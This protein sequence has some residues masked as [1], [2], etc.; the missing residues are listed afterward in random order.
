M[1]NLAVYQRV[2]HRQDHQHKTGED[3]DGDL[4][5]NFQVFHAIGPAGRNGPDG[6]GDA[7]VDEGAAEHAQIAPCKCVRRRRGSSHSIMPSAALLIHPYSTAVRCTVRM[8]PKVSQAWSVSQSGWCSLIEEVKPASEPSNS[9]KQAKAMNMKTGKALDWSDAMRS[10]SSV[11]S[12]RCSGWPGSSAAACME[13]CAASARAGSSTRPISPRAK[14]TEAAFGFSTS[15]PL[16][17][18]QMNTN[19]PMID[20]KKAP[21]RLRMALSITRLPPA[22]PHPGSFDS[23]ATDS[24]QYVWPA[25]WLVGRARHSAARQ[26]FDETA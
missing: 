9:Q 16:R 3:E 22:C 2:Q 6:S 5:R 26:S 7:H 10:C 19:R 13:S 23:R 24:G 4:P 11:A 1:F 17:E 20:S 12:A 21:S 8:R 14:I 18:D 15:R 25:R